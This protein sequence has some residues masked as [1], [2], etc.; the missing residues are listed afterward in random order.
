ML[1]TF[2]GLT[3]EDLAS[4][5]NKMNN[6]ELIKRLEQIKKDVYERRV[7]NSIRT[8]NFTINDLKLEL[9]KEEKKDE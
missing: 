2:Q 5:F 3:I 7:M 9:E 1:V 6:T 8:L 4:R